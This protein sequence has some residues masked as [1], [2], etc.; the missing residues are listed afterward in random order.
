MSRT[1]LLLHSME[2]ILQFLCPSTETR[3][4]NVLPQTKTKSLID[5]Q[6]YLFKVIGP[7]CWITLSWV[8]LLFADC[9]QI[10]PTCITQGMACAARKRPPTVKYSPALEKVTLRVFSQPFPPPQSVIRG[11]PTTPMERIAQCLHFVR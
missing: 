2:S 1:F 4:G 5:G 9:I 10:R 3:Y 7:S 11:A 8:D 6:V